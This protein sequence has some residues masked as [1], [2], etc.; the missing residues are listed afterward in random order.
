MDYGHDLYSDFC[1]EPPQ[2]KTRGDMEKDAA[3]ERFLHKKD[4][5]IPPNPILLI[6]VTNAKYPVDVEVMFKVTGI[7]GKVRECEKWYRWYLVFRISIFC[8]KFSLH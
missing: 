4:D 6:S 3:L 1:E 5:K 2:K 8:Y 7:I